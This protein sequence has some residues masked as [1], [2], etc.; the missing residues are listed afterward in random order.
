MDYVSHPHDTYLNRTYS[1]ENQ[2]KYTRKLHELFLKK[3]KHTLT[4]RYV[5]KGRDYIFYGKNQSKREM[6]CWRCSRK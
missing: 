3:F 5:N 2:S 1:N 4:D 6:E